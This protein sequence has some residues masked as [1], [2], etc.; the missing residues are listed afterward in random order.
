M[1]YISFKRRGEKQLCVACGKQGD[2]KFNICPKC[3]EKGITREAIARPS[4]EIVK[5]ERLQFE[6]LK[7]NA[8]KRGT[9]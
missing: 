8:N 6:W 7:A 9:R 1:E 2:I 5:K 3:K 4:Q